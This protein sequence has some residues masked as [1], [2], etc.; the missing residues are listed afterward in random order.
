MR[1]IHELD[2]TLP[3]SEAITA[4]LLAPVSRAP[5]KTP[6]GGA[7]GTT[8]DRF[9][10]GKTLLVVPGGRLARAVERRLLDRSRAEGAVLEAP[11][12]VTPLMLF[13]RFVV[14]SRP[15]LS[16]V[17]AEASWREAVERVVAT[18]PVLSA[19]IAAAFGSPGEL[20]VRLR[21]RL[22]ARLAKLSAEV[23]S[24]MHS[25]ASVR[26]AIESLASRGQ[27]EARLVEHWR[28]LEACA[29]VRAGIL[30]AAGVGDRDEALRDAL[31]SEKVSSSDGAL[32]SSRRSVA[33][34]A[35]SIGS[36]HL[37]DR[38]VILLADPEPVHRAL[39][40][41]LEAR[42]LS[43]ELCV[44]A[45]R[46]WTAAGAPSKGVSVP[47]PVVDDE[48]FP[49]RSRW[50][51]RVFG[52]DVIAHDAIRVG[53]GP[54][55]AAGE[56]VAA[57]RAIPAPRRS[58]EI[59]VMAPDDDTRRAI[60]AA[61]GEA[62]SS[63][64]RVESRVFSS[65]RLGTLLSR[66]EALLGEEGMDA[67]AAY[68]RHPDVA[69]ALAG[70]GEERDVARYRVETIADSWRDGISAADGAAGFRAMRDRVLAQ[71]ASLD[72]ER[73]IADWA[74]PIRAYLRSIVGEDAS[75]A[76]VDE[77][78]RSIS[79]LD[80]VLGEFADVPAAF[81]TPIRCAEAIRLLRAAVDR[82]EIRGERREQ[83]VSIVQWLDAGIADEP[84]L[85]LAG[86]ADGAVPEGDVTDV[87]IPDA[88]RRTLGLLSSERR[89]ARDAWI[90]D[91]MLRRMH[92][93]RSAGLPASVQFVVA[94]RSAS[95]DPLRPSRFLLRVESTA[96]AARV[97]RLFPAAREVEPVGSVGS[98]AGRS[99]EFPVRPKVEGSAFTSISVTA[100]S[101]Y[102]KC[103]YLFQLQRDPRLRLES[104]DERA[105]ELD[106]RRFGNLLHE[107][108]ELWGLD[109]KT[110]SQPT[111]DP[112]AIERAVLSYLDAA[113]ARELPPSSSSAVRVQLEILRA[114]L[115]RFAVMQARE[116][117]AGWHVRF[118]ELEYD[119][120]TGPML[121]AAG[122]DPAGQARGL[123]LVGRI[124]RVDRNV[125]TGAWR[126]LDYKSGSAGDAPSSTHLKGRPGKR[127]W[128]DLQL[129]LYRHLLA[130]GRLEGMQPIVV[131]SSGLGY[132][133]LAASAERSGFR[134][135]ECTA[136]EFDMAYDEARRVVDGVL[137][138]DFA[139]AERT[140]FPPDD[141]LAAV[142]GL[143][144][145]AQALGIDPGDAG[146]DDDA[147]GAA[148]SGGGA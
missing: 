9:Q 34:L 130:E 48:G 44:H 20:P 115:R 70:V 105:T 137:R 86:F 143:G 75:G 16:R 39:F 53:E 134:M 135:L 17:G 138:G 58:D 50:A 98:V 12:I 101:T 114:R 6:N 97:A 87:L 81:A 72:G 11:S 140:P 31:L 128:K 93:R 33:S 122:A 102:L 52:A 29:E 65:T 41:A 90:L 21:P 38:V 141:P 108:V 7:V 45:A 25:F 88:I 91:G 4:C 51:N 36:A 73:S 148:V 129:P 61:L 32:A 37:F 100:F 85:V 79:A 24:G 109:E 42:G 118:V 15:M 107:S 82:S 104:N 28:A 99:V 47:E 10:L 43:V 78:A 62:G 144:L 142:W 30:D 111:T 13:G 89:A 84:H 145:R 23:A 132:V 147:S 125:E 126:A 113:V 74:R 94:R 26:E 96:L 67:F 3:L 56:A 106:A 127:T 8:R 1:K 120:N 123:R 49:L 14:P 27:A 136:A 146:S 76:F 59:A 119:E 2:P 60:E 57:I 22:S 46:D 55:D 19:R 64:A 133:N 112:A 5:D 66:L 77:R 80:R 95:G 110:R 92:A 121:L 40:R 131:E 69:R 116:A 54:R 83:G 71:V 68:I 18:N 139:P 63:A 35:S 117:E 103:P 124:D